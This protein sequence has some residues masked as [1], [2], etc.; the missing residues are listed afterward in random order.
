MTTKDKLF[1]AFEGIDGCG[2]FT[3]IIK[4]KDWLDAAH[5]WFVGWSSEPNGNSGSAS[6]LGKAIKRILRHEDPA[7]SDPV[8]LQRI[9]VLERAQDIICLIDPLLRREGKLAYFIERF[10]FS[11]IA[12]GM[13]SGLPMQRFIDLH[14]EVIGPTMRWPD[15]T[16]IFDVPASVAVRRIAES[17]GKPEYF[18]RADM[19]GRVRSYYLQIAANPRFKD[20]TVV[21]DADRDPEAVFADVKRAIESFIS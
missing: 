1:I 4:A 16:L 3:Q 14:D 18:E 13:L 15:L 5:G 2:K 8:E 9:Y 17:R 12:Y 6:L 7:P 20:S 21:I 11:T 10:A 19:L